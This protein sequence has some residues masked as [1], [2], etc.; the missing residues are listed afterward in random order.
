MQ[1]KRKG[2]T[3]CTNPKLESKDRRE[4]REGEKSNLCAE[5]YTVNRIDQCSSLGYV[6]NISWWLYTKNQLSCLFGFCYVMFSILDSMAGAFRLTRM[7]F[8]GIF[9]F[10]PPKSCQ[11]SL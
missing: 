9:A 4:A 7:L 1:A 10:P 6:W 2:C 3:L 8:L 11:S 5:E